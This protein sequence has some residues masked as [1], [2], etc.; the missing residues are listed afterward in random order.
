MS[1]MVGVLM[2]VGARAGLGFIADL[3]SSPTQVGYMN[4]LAVVIFAG[5]AA[6]AVRLLSGASGVSTRPWRS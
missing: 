6:Q 5:P 1:L 2:V 3:L 4:G